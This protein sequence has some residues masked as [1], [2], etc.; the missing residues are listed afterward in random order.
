MLPTVEIF[1]FNLSLHLH[2][3]LPGTR[4]LIWIL[5]DNV[6]CELRPE[7]NKRNG[8]THDDTVLG[9]VHLHQS[10]NNLLHQDD[11]ESDESIA[12]FDDDAR[13]NDLVEFV[14]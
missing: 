9:N 10:C 8:S 12:L 1:D 4:N 13:C 2:A 14:R 6:R 3:H 7:S 11:R 5:F